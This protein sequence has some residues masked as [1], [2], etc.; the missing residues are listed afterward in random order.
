MM[1]SVAMN[2]LPYYRNPTMAR[3]AQKVK[4]TVRGKNKMNQIAK[5]RLENFRDRFI[6]LWKKSAWVLRQK[7]T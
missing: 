4:S 2:R 6:V 7:A 1:D 5:H 3:K